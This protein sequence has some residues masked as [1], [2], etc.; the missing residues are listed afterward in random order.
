MRWRWVVVAV[1]VAVGGC[2]TNAAGR[3]EDGAAPAAPVSAG[4]SPAGPPWYSVVD[5]GPTISGAVLETTGPGAV[6]NGWDDENRFSRLWTYTGRVLS[7]KVD[8]NRADPHAD[9]R[10]DLQR[11]AAV[12]Q[13]AGHLHVPLTGIGDGGIA[14][15]AKHLKGAGRAVIR[16][17]VYSGNAVASILLPTEGAITTEQDLAAHSA[18]LIAALTEVLDDLRAQ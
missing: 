13:E 16:A 1:M 14:I 6:P 15:L 5:E 8:I 9:R 7:V 12:S 10:Q 2:G 18:E 17:N 4:S 11:D 3:P